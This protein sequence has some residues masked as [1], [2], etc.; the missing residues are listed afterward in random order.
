MDG[1]WLWPDR[2]WVVG[3]WVP[4]NGTD[5]CAVNVNGCT[6][7]GLRRMWVVGD[8]IELLSK[9]G[10]HCETVWDIHYNGYNIDTVLTSSE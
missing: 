9:Y 6:G 7:V 2:F 3:G 8:T 1:R 4:R 5:I 10:A